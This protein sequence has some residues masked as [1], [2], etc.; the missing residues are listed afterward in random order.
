MLNKL[1]HR[2]INKSL[3]AKDIEDSNTPPQP[4]GTLL[5]ADLGYV[6]RPRKQLFRQH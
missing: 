6:S 5:L 4:L 1:F 3:N 2:Q